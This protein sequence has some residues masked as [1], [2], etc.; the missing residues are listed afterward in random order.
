VRS[1]QG[2]TSNARLSRDEV[3]AASAEGD[4]SSSGE[5]TDASI[6]VEAPNMV[7]F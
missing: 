6:A 7:G 2:S 1:V 5:A 4:V 3:R